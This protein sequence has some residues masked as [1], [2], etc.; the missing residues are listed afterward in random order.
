L[1]PYGGNVFTMQGSSVPA[2]RFNRANGEARTV[3]L[4]ALQAPGNAVFN[5]VR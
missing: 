4:A 3:E 1:T 5:R 2:A